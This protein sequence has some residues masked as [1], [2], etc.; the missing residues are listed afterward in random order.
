[1]SDHDFEVVD[2]TAW[3]VR[4]EEPTGGDEKEWLTDRDG[5]DWLFKPVV[6]HENEGFVQG[7]DWSEKVSAEMARLVGVPCATVE[8]AVRNGRRGSISLDLK[9]PKWELQPGAVLLAQTVPDYVSGDR[10]RRGHSLENIRL[11]LER[12][13][14]PPQAAVPTSFRAFDVFVGYL[15]LDAWIA[16]RDRH[17][18]NWRCCCHLHPRAVGFSPARMITPR[19]SGST[20]AIVR[21]NADCGT[22]QSAPGRRR[23]MRTGSSGRRARGRESR[24]WSR[25]QRRRAPSPGGTYAHTG[26]IV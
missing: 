2:V 12:Y 22:K 9:P 16:N 10:H 7:E 6:E 1:M 21:E 14:P 5:R 24:L 15:I 13:G 19:V 23:A 17:D 20:S 26:P 25:S 11:A 18:E 4:D 8:L 3:R